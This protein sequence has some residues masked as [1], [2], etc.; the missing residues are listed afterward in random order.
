MEI[1]NKTV[2]VVKNNFIGAIVGAGAGFLVAKKVI[3][4]EKTWLKIVITIVG[5]GVGA[6]AQSKFFAKKGAPT[7]ATVKK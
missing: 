3:K 1:V 4:T 2:S 5:A 7:S 6:T